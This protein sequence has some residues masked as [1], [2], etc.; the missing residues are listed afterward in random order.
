MPAGAHSRRVDFSFIAS[1]SSAQLLSVVGHLHNRTMS[2]ELEP[3][4][5]FLSC[6]IS[7]FCAANILTR[8]APPFRRLSAAKHGNPTAMYS[9][10]QYYEGAMSAPD[11][12]VSWAEATVWYK[13]LINAHHLLEEE[14]G[15]EE[16]LAVEMH[17][18]LAKV[19]EMY[20]TGG[21]GLDANSA[22]AASYYNQ[23][24]EEAE[25]VFP[26]QRSP[27]HALFLRPPFS[28]PPFP[29]PLDFP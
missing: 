3:G 13:R 6:R 11:V 24:A 20:E 16:E 23:A 27:P 15:D 8:L 26:L 1:S 7:F 2:P 29:L 21:N 12:G 17:R 25:N 4:I 28:E 10:A 18:I 19:A 9:V 5:N 14:G 22:R